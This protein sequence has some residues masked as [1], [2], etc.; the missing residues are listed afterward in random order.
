MDH[1][2]YAGGHGHVTYFLSRGHM[3]R[4]KKGLLKRLGRDTET[5]LS[6]PA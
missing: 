5:T 6:L 2:V 3:D 1:P 4:L